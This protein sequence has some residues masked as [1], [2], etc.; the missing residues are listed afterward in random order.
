[1]SMRKMQ[2]EI[3]TVGNELLNGRTENTNAS[4]LSRE[5]QNIGFSV[6][7]HT[8]VADRASDIVQSLMT[9]VNRSNVIVYTGGL[10][11]TDDDLTKET[12][13]KALGMTLKEDAETLERIRVFFESRGREMKDNNRKQA[14]VPEGAEIL[15]NDNGTAPGIFIRK[16]EQTIILLPGPP[17]EMEPMFLDKAVPKLKEL[18]GQKIFSRTLGVS[19]IGESELEV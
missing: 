14:L 9:A 3:V 17:H 6:T 8:T 5:L 15:E 1:M 13:A 16:D 12:V 11:P 2:A 10:G 18:S 7:N 19:G 4:F